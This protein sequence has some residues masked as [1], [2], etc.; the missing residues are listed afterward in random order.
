MNRIVS[1][2][3]LGFAGV[4]TIILVPIAYVVFVCLAHAVF[5][6]GSDDAEFVDGLIGYL[7]IATLVS[8]LMAGLGAVL[9]AIGTRLGHDWVVTVAAWALGPL[10]LLI[11]RISMTGG[12][13]PNFGSELRTLLSG[14]VLSDAWLVWPVLVGAPVFW[15]VSRRKEASRLGMETSSHARWTFLTCLGLGL[16]MFFVLPVL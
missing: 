11:W 8:I 9:V 2:R 15:A 7:M 6:W 5:H 4:V 13:G 3:T 1:F 10:L 16:A 14:G 12:L